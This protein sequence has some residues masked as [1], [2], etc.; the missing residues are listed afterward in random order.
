MDGAPPDIAQADGEDG[1]MSD[2]DQL[3]YRIRILPEQLE[4]ARRRYKQLVW[5]AA[6]LGMNDLLTDAWDMAIV[7]GQA[8]AIS[9]GG[10]IGFGD[11][12]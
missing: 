5:E 11:G 1:A 9:K 6:E 8:K 10:S 3:V 4:R 2:T 7:E 12:K